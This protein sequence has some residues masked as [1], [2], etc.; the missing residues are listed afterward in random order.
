VLKIPQATATADNNSLTMFN[1][2]FEG[3]FNTATYKAEYL[4][5][6]IC[7]YPQSVAGTTEMFTH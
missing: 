5:V 2:K 7:S 6:T 4:Q 3:L 1:T